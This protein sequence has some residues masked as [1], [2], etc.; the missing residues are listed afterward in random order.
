MPRKPTSK[1][2]THNILNKIRASLIKIDQPELRDI[3]LVQARDGLNQIIHELGFERKPAPVPVVKHLS[4]LEQAQAKPAPV[5]A[6]PFK[7][8][9]R[10]GLV[11]VTWA[12]K[13]AYLA[14]KALLGDKVFG[15]SPTA[16]EWRASEAWIR[17]NKPEILAGLGLK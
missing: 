2:I 1:T 8:E 7:A 10:Q 14:N 15:W 9:L 4:V 6:K 16:K 17:K 5:Q 3:A 11:V 12:D 13:A